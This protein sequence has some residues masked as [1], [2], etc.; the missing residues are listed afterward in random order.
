M[1]GAGE[2]FWSFKLAFHKRLVDDHLGRD[3]REFTPLSR[4]HLLSHRLEVALHPV[5]PN[6][7]AVDQRE[8]F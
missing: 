1:H 3:V 5:N 4:L 6:R 7:D 8:R 2:V